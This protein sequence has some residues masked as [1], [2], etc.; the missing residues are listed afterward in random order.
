MLYSLMNVG[1]TLVL[2][3]DFFYIGPHTSVYISSRTLVGLIAP[4][5]VCFPKA[6]FPSIHGSQNEIF[7]RDKS[8]LLARTSVFICSR[9]DS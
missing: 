1:G 9:V 2:P 4:T 5:D 6:I 7:L 8:A 3:I